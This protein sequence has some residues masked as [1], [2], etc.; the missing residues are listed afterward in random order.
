MRE[1]PGGPAQGTGGP[2][3]DVVWPARPVEIVG[4]LEAGG[5]R[6]E[7]GNEGRVR[8]S[9]GRVQ[10]S[11]DRVRGSGIRAGSCWPG[12]ANRRDRRGDT[13]ESRVESREL[14]WYTA[15]IAG[16]TRAGSERGAGGVAAGGPRV[17]PPR[18]RPLASR[19]A[20][21]KLHLVSANQP[22]VPITC[23]PDAELRGSA[24]RS[25]GS[26]R[27]KTADAP[28]AEV[29]EPHGEGTVPD[30]GY[31]GRHVSPSE[32]SFLGFF[33]RRFAGL[34]F[35]CRCSVRRL[36]ASSKSL[37]GSAAS[38]RRRSCSYNA[39]WA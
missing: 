2:A 24:S 16:A 35:S 18:G 38:I 26:E 7:A 27:G 28:A 21:R 19:R 29:A 8:G 37:V 15:G 12:R 6:R 4:R 17:P 39:Y 23:A 5:R 9:G 32:R 13:I 25:G 34:V 20:V 30:G 11:G 33:A 14:E 10:G 36:T 3:P 22:A 1:S 31:N